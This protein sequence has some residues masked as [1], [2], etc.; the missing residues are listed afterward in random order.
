LSV[1]LIYRKFSNFLNYFHHNKIVFLTFI[2]LVKKI[3]VFADKRLNNLGVHDGKLAPCLNSANC[4]CSQ[5]S[6]AVHQIPPLNFTSNPE[7]AI[8]AVKGIIQSLSI[9]KIITESNDYLYVELKSA[10]LGF[11]DDVEFYLNRNTNTIQVRSAS[12]L[13]YGDLGVSRQRIEAIRTNFN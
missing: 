3:I 8:A 11:V 1:S 13:G 2:F 7:E 4:V 6:D 9:T 10:F 5:N 12:R